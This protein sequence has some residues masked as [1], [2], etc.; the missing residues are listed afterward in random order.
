MSRIRLLVIA[1]VLIAIIVF[2]VRSRKQ[3]LNTGAVQAQYRIPCVAFYEE[4]QPDSESAP[5][6]ADSQLFTNLPGAVV[7]VEDPLGV[8]SGGFPPDQCILRGTDNERTV[9]LS[10]TL[11]EG[12]QAS[13]ALQFEVRLPPGNNAIESP[14]ALVP[15]IGLRLVSP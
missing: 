6:N 3:V 15:R 12:Y 4:P 1:V 10:V 8:D 7:Q 13:S 14:S 2:V 11:P 5:S 9:K